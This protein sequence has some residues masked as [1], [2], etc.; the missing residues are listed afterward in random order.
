[1]PSAA[2]V[3]IPSS[4]RRR[5]LIAAGLLA[6]ALL[7]ACRA[8]GGKD[9]PLRQPSK[10]RLESSVRQYTRTYLGG[11]GLVTY[12]LLS[13]RCRAKIAQDDFV[14]LSDAA[15]VAY[16]D[17]PIKELTVEVSGNTGYA[18]YRFDKSELDQVRERWV[19]VHE[20]SGDDTVD[21][22][23]ND[24]CPDDTEEDQSSDSITPV[25]N[26]GSRAKPIAKGAGGPVA[27]G[28]WDL[29]VVSTTPN[30]NAAV[31]KENQFNDPPDPGKQ[32]FIVRVAFTR[33]GTDPD[34]PSFVEL[35]SIGTGNVTYDQYQDTC[36]VFPDPIPSKD[37]YP[38]GAIEANVCW[39]VA[40][41]DAP[42]L[43]LIARNRFDGA[44][45]TFFA[46]M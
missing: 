29:R 46:L 1:M 44:E 35:R 39:Q 17:Q 2:S 18:T 10:A 15:K 3:A 30:A 9:N 4:N 37:V 32:F 27:G 40:V 34:N 21:A 43:L 20:G 28:G 25:D 36:G 41:G 14:A 16:G 12:A 33:T 22:W 31:A 24:D 5:K 23:R 11:L 7:S 45:G 8:D 19:F 42:T 26:P 13:P 38:G 6:T